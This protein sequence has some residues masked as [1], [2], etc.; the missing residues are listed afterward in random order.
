LIE[1]QGKVFDGAVF[2][3]MINIKNFEIN[4]PSGNPL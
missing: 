2:Q 1:I 4:Q 3:E